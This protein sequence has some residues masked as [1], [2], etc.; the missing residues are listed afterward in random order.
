MVTEDG[1]SEAEVR[2][3]TQVGV[4][5]WRKVEGVMLD[6]NILKKLNGKVLRT[7]VTPVCLYG[8]ETVVLTITEA[9]S[10]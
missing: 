4:N 7:C 3:R 2:R 9:A 8:L 10:L 6:R 1:H 5:A